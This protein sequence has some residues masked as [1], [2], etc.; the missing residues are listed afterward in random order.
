LSVICRK[1][2]AESNLPVSAT[3]PS[4]RARPAE[5]SQGNLKL[6]A[7]I[8]ITISIERCTLATMITLF[9]SVPGPFG[10]SRLEHQLDRL[11]RP[12]TVAI[13]WRDRVILLFVFLFVCLWTILWTRSILNNWKSHAQWD[14]FAIVFLLAFVGMWLYEVRREL[15]NRPI[16]IEGEFALG[17]VTSQRDVGGRTKKSKIAYEFTDALGR[18]WNGRGYDSTKAYTENMSLM[19]FYEPHDPSQNVTLCATVW[20]L[21]SADGNLISPF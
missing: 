7:G 20:R 17:K 21:R 6:V 19:V 11:Q 15:R 16:L 5:C 13:A 14:V 8:R 10:D 9:G 2:S 18:T 12:R 3:R 1:G 4:I